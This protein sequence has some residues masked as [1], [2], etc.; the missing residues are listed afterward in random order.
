MGKTYSEYSEI[1][2]RKR[3]EGKTLGKTK[4]K[5]K[6]GVAKETEQRESAAATQR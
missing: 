6:Y 4:K 1:N 2:S 3:K 5:R